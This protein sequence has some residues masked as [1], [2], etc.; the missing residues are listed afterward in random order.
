M[1]LIHDALK[2]FDVPQESQNAV[3]RARAV[4]ARARPAWLDAT[5]AFVVVLLGGVLGL[6]VW[7]SQLQKKAT[8][9]PIAAAPAFATVPTSASPL[10]GDAAASSLEVPAPLHAMDPQPGDGGNAQTA[11]VNQQPVDTG[12]APLKYVQPA[13]APTP[14][15]QTHKAAASEYGT[16]A[17]S[18]A[19]QAPARLARSNKPAA[20]AASNTPPPA[21]D[22]APIELRFARFVTAMKE[23]RTDDAKQELAALKDRLPAGSLGLLRAQAW[24]DLRAGSDASAADGYRTILERMPGDEEAAIHLA[25]IK[26]RQQKPEEARA[27][28]DAAVRLQPDSAPLRA[29]LAQ[30]TPT[31]RQ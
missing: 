7:Q 1:S 5:L 30:F 8:L 27:T 2:S 18:A 13:P 14:D 16:D 20:T 25:S 26:S 15:A 24:F 11:V 12:A 10:S 21:V 17:P 9:S 31:A 3:A 22:D 23:D 4:P 6:D 28:L 19:V 29:A